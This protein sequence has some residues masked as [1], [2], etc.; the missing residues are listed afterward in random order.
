MVILIISWILVTILYALKDLLSSEYK[1]MLLFIPVAASDLSYE[2]KAVTFA[3]MF[4]AIFIYKNFY[5]DRVSQ[6][7]DDEVEEGEGYKLLFTSENDDNKE[8]NKTQ[9]SN[10]VDKIEIEIIIK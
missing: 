7:S 4:F 1:W 10:K 5:K 9:E 8:T 2:V 6:E 3:L